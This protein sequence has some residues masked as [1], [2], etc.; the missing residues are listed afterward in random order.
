MKPAVN[1]ASCVLPYRCNNAV[2]FFGI[3]I[4]FVEFFLN[5][6]VIVKF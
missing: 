3:F 5:V 6:E 1:T 2:I 4:S